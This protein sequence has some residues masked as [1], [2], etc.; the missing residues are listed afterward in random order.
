MAD[1]KHLFKPIEIAGVELRNR[2]FISPHNVQYAH[3]DGTPS[4]RNIHYFVER[5]KNGVALIIADGTY[6]MKEGRAFRC[7]LGIYD[8]RLIPA[9]RRMADAVH[10]AGA[11]FGVQLLH[12][13]RQGD[14]RFSN[15][16]TEAPSAIKCP[17][18]Q[19]PVVEMSRE[20]IR[21]VIKGYGQGALRAKKAGVDLIELHGAHGFL[22]SQFVS[23]YSN[24]RTDEYGGSFENRT[25]FTKEIIDEIRQVCG[26]EFPV[27]IRIS[28]DELV[29]DGMTVDD[30]EIYAKK[31]EEWGVAYISACVGVFEPNAL[32]MQISPM[33][34]PFAPLEYLAAAM[35]Q[36]VAIPV[37]AANSIVDPVLAD[38][39]IEK[40]SADMVAMTRSHIADPEILKK[41][42][43]GRLDDI[44]N[45]VRCNH[46]CI[47][48]LF[49]DLDVTCTVNPQV[50]R[51]KE[52][53]IKP[54]VVRKKVVVIGGGPSGLEAARVAGLRGHH[55]VLF[56]KERELGGL[57]RY[58]QLPPKKEELGGVTRWQI[59][60]LEK[61]DIEKRI[62]VE[63]NAE[64]ILAEN[65]DAIIVA[66]GSSSHVPAVDGIFSNDGKL[67]KNVKT[68]FDV[69]T[70]KAEV[71][72]RVVVIGANDIGLETAEFL[73]EK[74]KEVTV[75][76]CKKA[77]SQE[78][79]G[80][81]SWMNYLP[82]LAEKQVKLLLDKFVKAI[83]DDGVLLD[84][85]G[86]MP[87]SHREGAIGNMEE[88]IYKADT[89]VVGT[90]RRSVDALF[91]GLV[92]KTKKIYKIG[93][94]REPRH[95]YRAVKEG[96][97][98]GLTV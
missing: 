52:L 31:L 43:E 8:D 94:A 65:P 69:L 98:A 85:A 84:V 44:R 72:N 15:G 34:V 76:D 78:I 55:V 97:E 61:L 68:V 36:V 11:K 96:F 9:W 82:R 25:R 48:R 17:L 20:R 18:L 88:E 71:G 29:P 39:I 56:E 13:G 59:M 27:G 41:A 33:E 63:A 79:I 83:T 35:K 47:D 19:A 75:V 93:D 90:G 95:T 49:C 87:P 4:D 24:K 21:E 58:A 14:I 51:E 67:R 46:G 26:K 81:I 40:G 28:V 16:M 5:A 60:Q 92:G 10:K 77:P 12:P 7:Q 66:T 2:V 1:L 74:G 64:R 23:P 22:I 32:L 30:S 6:F 91:E 73:K 38:Q 54:A 50:G 70:G 62:G 37:F 57:N 42:K 86:I 45:C 53:E 89:I 80:A 3:T